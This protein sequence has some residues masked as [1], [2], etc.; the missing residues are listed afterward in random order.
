MQFRK[1]NTNLYSVG[2]SHF[3]SADT[4][5]LSATN[6]NIQKAVDEG[7][8]REDLFYRLSVFP[9]HMPP[10]RDRKEDILLLLDNFLQKYSEEFDKSAR[11]FTPKARDRLLEYSWPGNVRELEN[12]IIKAI[13]MTNGEEISERY[14]PRRGKEE[15]SLTFTI[16]IGSTLEDTEKKLI[17][18]TLIH[19]CGN[20]SKTAKILQISR[21]ALYN[22]MHY[23]D[24]ALLSEEQ[25][26]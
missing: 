24:L 11:S 8:F 17:D 25:E 14:L 21:K 23:Y 19:T 4:R 13:I 9:I 20:K 12:S 1:F 22:K 6:D 2:G 18:A 3:I 7:R 15:K 5:I 10:L 16:E 26:A